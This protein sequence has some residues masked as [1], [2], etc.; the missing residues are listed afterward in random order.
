MDL[1]TL[2]WS[3]HG[4]QLFLC[5]LRPVQK[6]LSKKH[7]EKDE[8]RKCVLWEFTYPDVYCFCVSYGC[9]KTKQMLLVVLKMWWLKKKK[10]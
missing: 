6:L 5:T 10:H 7:S 3:L 8:D 4:W 2:G 1:K 9:E